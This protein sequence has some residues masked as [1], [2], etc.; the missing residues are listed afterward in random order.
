MQKWKKFLA[1]ILAGVMVF[2]SSLAAKP[3][4]L[5]AQETAERAA[6]GT[7]EYAAPGTVYDIYKAFQTGDELGDAW[8][9][10]EFGDTYEVTLNSS[11]S[12][13]V[14]ELQYQTKE[15]DNGKLLATFECNRLPKGDAA[16]VAAKQ[17]NGD[18]INKELSSF[19]IYESIDGGRTWG[20]GDTE[21][22]ARGENYLP[23]GFLCCL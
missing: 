16:L 4:Q 13:R 17:N 15:E 14:I 11:I 18:N 5:Q 8:V 9:D 23:V 2:E 7:A 22:P 19:P 6:Q 21:Q 1:G 20:A 12:P 3:V 10:P